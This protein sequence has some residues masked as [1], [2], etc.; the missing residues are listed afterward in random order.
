MSAELLF[1]AAGLIRVSHG[2]TADEG[3]LDADPFWVA[4]AD[5][6]AVIA[7]RAEEVVESLPPNAS[8]AEFVVRSTVDGYNEACA[9]A[10]AYIERTET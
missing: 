8:R 10:R 1:E 6:L 4:V 2:G 3:Y 9:V 7:T 5:W